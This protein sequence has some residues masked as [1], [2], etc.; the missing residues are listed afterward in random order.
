MA[1]FGI[2]TDMASSYW[3]LREGSVFHKLDVLYTDPYA[4]KNT[5]NNNVGENNQCFMVTVS[6]DHEQ[7]KSL[8]VKPTK[9][10]MVKLLLQVRENTLL[11][12]D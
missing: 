12:R 2:G 11:D 6:S 8:E 3:Y 1:K 7:V 10:K 5:V 4:D 9:D